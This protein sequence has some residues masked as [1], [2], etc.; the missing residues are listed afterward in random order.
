MSSQQTLTAIIYDRKGRVLS[1]GQNSYIKTHPL[2]ALHARKV[3]LEHRIYLHAEIAAIVRCADITRAWRMQIIRFGR[4]GQPA[5]AAPCAVCMSALAATP[6]RE[7]DH[8]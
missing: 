2:Q 3:G 8:T 6:I 5:N 4:N 1:I 7:I